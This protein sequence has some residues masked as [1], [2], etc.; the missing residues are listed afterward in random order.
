MLGMLSVMLL[1]MVV[2]V[3]DGGG[4]G[5]GVEVSSGRDRLHGVKQFD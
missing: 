3:L 2:E 4:G 5:G 1:V